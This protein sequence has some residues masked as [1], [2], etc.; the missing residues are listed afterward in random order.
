[1][2]I[3][4][5]GHLEDGPEGSTGEGSWIR[6]RTMQLEGTARLITRGKD[7]G[8][9][10]L[11]TRLFVEAGYDLVD[12]FELVSSHCEDMLEQGATTGSY[13]VIGRVVQ[14][15]PDR[16]VI[17]RVHDMSIMIKV[18]DDVPAEPS[19]G[20]RLKFYLLGLSLWDIHA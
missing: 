9:L 4:I 12:K 2:E 1:M 11:G 19:Q 8:T 5:I 15:W 18:P 20:T 6:F 16:V 7:A 13:V 17:V 10:A 14:A 3:I